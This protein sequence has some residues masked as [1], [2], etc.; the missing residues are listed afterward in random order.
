MLIN[1]QCC[2]R[3]DSRPICHVSLDVCTLISAAGNHASSLGLE[4]LSGHSGIPLA[5][6]LIGLTMALRLVND[7]QTLYVMSISL[8]DNMGPSDKSYFRIYSPQSF[9]Q[10]QQQHQ[11]Q[12]QQHQKQHKQQHKLSKQPAES[13]VVLWVVFSLC[14]VCCVRPVQQHP[15]C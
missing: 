13:C 9:K 10:Q 15:V 1:G 12:Q 4:L 5:P 8:I 3:D 2:R 6:I 14:V 7:A 11:K